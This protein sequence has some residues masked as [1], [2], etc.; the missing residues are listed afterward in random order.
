MQT[1][2]LLFS[3]ADAV[4]SGS[5]LILFKVLTLSVS[6]CTVLLHLS[7]FCY[8]LSPVADFSNT[9]SRDSNLSRT[10]PLFTYATG[11]AVWN[12]SLK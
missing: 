5:W 3:T 12:I 2:P 6:I 1:M 7:N 8:C 4:S 9:G 11:Y 10:R